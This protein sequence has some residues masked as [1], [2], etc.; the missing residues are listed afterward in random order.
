MSYYTRVFGTY[1]DYS[2]AEILELARKRD[3][4]SSGP[5]IPFK[6]KVTPREPTELE[7]ALELFE[8]LPAESYAPEGSLDHLILLLPSTSWE[9]CDEHTRE[10]LR[11]NDERDVVADIFRSL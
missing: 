4:R 6:P 2:I 3:D 11:S 10:V 5:E 1:S 8:T 7:R 9:G